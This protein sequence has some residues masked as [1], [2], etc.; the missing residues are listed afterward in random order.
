MNQ[1]S[2]EDVAK[3]AAALPAR[4]VV[5]G[6]LPRWRRKTTEELTGDQKR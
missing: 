3:M 4:S 6:E 2:A 5:L 1:A